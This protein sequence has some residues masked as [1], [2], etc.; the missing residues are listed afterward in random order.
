LHAYDLATLSGPIVVRR[1]RPGEKLV[2]LD[3]VE[4]ELDP[5]DLLITD[6]AGGRAERVLRLAGVMGG[7]E[8]EVSASTTDVLLEGA[9]FG[10][11]SI[12]RTSRR[13]KLVSEAAKRFE[14]GVAAR[15]QRVAVQRAAELLV[16]LGGGVIEE[17]LTDVDQPSPVAP[18]RFELDHP[19]RLVGVP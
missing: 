4:R 10:P 9:H 14:R 19:A 7:A 18:M 1:A 6:G 5:E 15:L 3:D 8:T 11:V 2:T 17:A 16:E 12:A 13:H